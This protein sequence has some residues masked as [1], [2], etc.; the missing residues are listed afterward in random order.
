MKKYLEYLGLISF[1]LFSFYY[2]D[3]VTNII[4]SKDPIMISIKEYASNNIDNCKEGYI[5]SDGVVLGKNGKEVNTR[6]SYSNMQGK[7]FNEELLVFDEITC[8]VNLSSVKKEYIMNANPSKNIISIFIKIDNMK[9]IK[10]I[11][12]IAN[13]KNVKLNILLDG[14]TL[15]DNKE[16]FIELYN[17]GHYIIYNGKDYDDLKLF[18]NV[19][20]D[21]YC[22]KLDDNNLDFCLKES[23][24]R[25]KT[26]YIYNDKIL[27][28]TK[29]DLEKGSFYI[30]KE[31]KN[32]YKEL[33]SVISYINAKHINIVNIHEALH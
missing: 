7:E 14:K 15:N 33:S 13:S 19:I 26:N 6:E 2:T 8:K 22:M 24:Q 4:S 17:E 12:E 29:N 30:F 9:Y 28:N 16:Y 20:N 23:I 25:L 31:N 27:K 21:T 11:V 32:T 5:T 10:D 3:K 1:T 18:L